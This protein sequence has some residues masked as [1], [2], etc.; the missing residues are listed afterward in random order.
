MYKLHH[1]GKNTS[2]LDKI[3]VNKHQIIVLC[4]FVLQNVAKAFILFLILIIDDKKIQEITLQY[5]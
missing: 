2:E 5:T 1:F 4:L 3:A